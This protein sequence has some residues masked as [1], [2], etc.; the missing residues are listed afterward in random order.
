LYFEKSGGLE[1]VK[2]ADSNRAKQLEIAKELVSAESK[3]Y[4][5]LIPLQ[6]EYDSL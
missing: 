1:N 3:K 6:K 2:K 5:I 4:A